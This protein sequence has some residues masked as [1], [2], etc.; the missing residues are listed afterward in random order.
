MN[1]S[2][3]LLLIESVFR[4]GIIAVVTVGA[5]LP[6][7]AGAQQFRLEIGVDKVKTGDAPTAKAE[8]PKP[9][10]TP[11]PAKAG[12]E[13]Q[14]AKPADESKPAKSESK[15]SPVM[16]VFPKAAVARARNVAPA[17]VQIVVPGFANQN[18]NALEPQIRARLEPMLRTEL[19]FANRA[20]G[21]NDDER[22]ALIAA[23]KKWLDAFVV[24][25]A[26]HQDPNQRQM[27][28]QGMRVIGGPQV[29]DDPRESVQHG[30]AEVVAAT[31][32]AEKVVAYEN[33]CGKRSAFYRQVI[34]D[35]LVALIDTK[36]ILSPEQR[37]KITT[38]LNDHWD[39][40]WAPQLELFAMNNDTWPNVPDQWVLPELTPSQRSVLSQLNRMSN[41]MIINGGA[42]GLEVGEI[43]DISL[44]DVPPQANTA[45]K[46]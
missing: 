42:F 32:P 40:S 26:K 6:M 46:D 1:K 17:P 16:R 44:D 12:D 29:G 20:A 21:L 25:F 5:V 11:H 4:I 31:L 36:V 9:D 8:E 37:Q 28:L 10:H 39:P 19:S 34:V 41:R 45:K 27:W 13:V 30:V 18:P 24:D 38:S 35:N 33:E 22:R 15:P 7:S 2:T 43:D 3:S 23:S 14:V